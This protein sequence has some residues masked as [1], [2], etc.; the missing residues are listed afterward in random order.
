M[1][2]KKPGLETLLTLK[3][4]ARDRAS[5][6]RSTLSEPVAQS[7]YRQLYT[8]DPAHLLKVQSGFHQQ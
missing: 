5:E 6:C 2:Q 8:L 1:Q 7:G 3:R 4:T